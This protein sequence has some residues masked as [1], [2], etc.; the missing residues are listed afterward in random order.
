MM[1][2]TANERKDREEAARA[3]AEGKGC[4][5]YPLAHHTPL[6]LHSCSFFISDETSLSPL[7]SRPYLTRAYEYT[8]YSETFINRARI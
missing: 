1:A 7:I 3:A 5:L 6:S 2:Q 4:P 8:F